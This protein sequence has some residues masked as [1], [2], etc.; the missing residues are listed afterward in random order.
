MPFAAGSPHFAPAPQTAVLV[1]APVAY[2]QGAQT[3]LGFV[4][5]P[6]AA[7]Q[8][9][10]SQTLLGH[11]GPELAAAMPRPALVAASGPAP[12]HSTPPVAQPPAAL[13][14]QRNAYLAPAPL[15]E[16]PAPF[17]DPVAV[18][19][20]LPP[21]ARVEIERARRKR[22]EQVEA[23]RRRKQED[24][25]QRR[26]VFPA[27]SAP[28]RSD[29]GRVTHWLLGSTLVGLLT[30]LGIV[31]AIG[32]RKDVE[33]EIS[34]RDGVDTL[35]L[36][37]D[38]CDDGSRVVLQGTE[39]TFANHVALL[40]LPSQ[41]P[42]GINH[43]EPTLIDGQLIGDQTVGLD[44][45]VHF[46]LRPDLSRLGQVVPELSIAVEAKS[47][48]F[49]SIDDEQVPITQGAGHVQLALR[50]LVG[51]AGEIQTFERSLVYQV[52][53]R[54]GRAHAGKLAFTFNATPLS[55]EAPGPRVILEGDHFTLAGKT[56]RGAVLRLDG[57][58]L[59]VASDGRFA[60]LLNV[61]SLGETTIWLSATLEG[62]ATRRVPIQVKRVANLHEEAKHF[63][64][65]ASENFARFGANPEDEKGLAVA[66]EGTIRTVREK[67][68]ATRALLDVTS[69]CVGR[70]VAQVTHGA[71]LK[72][73]ENTLVVA[74]GHVSGSVEA[75]DGSRIPEIR[76]L[77][78][79]RKKH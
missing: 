55:I 24:P 57:S 56:A 18:A 7:P 48:T 45:P 72:F 58:P 19:D 67:G 23:R 33:G 70:C 34:T 66:L 22:D 61:D 3:Q 54:D 62:H 11:R 60:Q 43:L 73:V 15:P 27:M 77:M 1:P 68:Y 14:A 32:S 26:G 76:T 29:S 74:Y 50:E 49:V 31:V 35:E 9:P 47:D 65:T 40:Q 28:P 38:R 17:P 79:L 42:I 4:P 46:R 78:V 12:S 10:P 63:A 30:A 75:P 8:V 16:H 69:G 64:L 52:K 59:P 5:Q 51:E 2:P 13:A 37:C 71:R 41:L 6:P 25:L 53:P 21:A 20:R 44:L 39:A 36:R